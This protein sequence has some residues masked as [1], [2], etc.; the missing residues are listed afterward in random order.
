MNH[1]HHYLSDVR[2]YFTNT[3]PCMLIDFVIPIQKLNLIVK[4]LCIFQKLKSF[5]LRLVPQEILIFT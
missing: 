5:V 1:C 2:L 4:G 3:L